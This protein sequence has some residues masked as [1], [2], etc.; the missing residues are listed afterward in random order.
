MG[1]KLTAVAKLIGATFLFTSSLAAAVTLETDANG[2]LVGVSGLQVDTELFDVVFV[3]DSCINAFGGCNDA[4]SDFT[5]QTLDDATAASSALLDA[6][7]NSIFLD[8]PINIFGCSA[9]EVCG[10]TTP[11]SLSTTQPRVNAA[12]L[13]I[14]ATFQNGLD[15][16]SFTSFLTAADLTDSPSSV[17]A[18]YTAVAP[19]PLPAAAWLFVSALGLLGFRVKQRAQQS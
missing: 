4:I 12:T 15:S 3:D 17:Y 8:Q 7:A 19:V 11:Y 6:L 1:I 10:I 5:F 13:D 16:T 2:Q 14:R 9:L 18:A